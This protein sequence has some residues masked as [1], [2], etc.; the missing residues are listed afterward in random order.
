[1]G[2]F[3]FFKNFNNNT[4]GYNLNTVFNGI[5]EGF[6]V[7]NAE[8]HVRPALL[9]K[10]NAELIDGNFILNG[11]KKALCLCTTLFVIQLIS[12]A[13]CSFFN[14]VKEAVALRECFA[15]DND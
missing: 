2:F 15:G 13:G 5:S 11:Y 10:N 4:N 9:P 8:T 14:R 3:D 6:G 1:M 7:F 12:D